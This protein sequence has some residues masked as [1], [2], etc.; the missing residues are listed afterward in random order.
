MLMKAF[1]KIGRHFAIVVIALFCILGIP[2]LQSDVFATWKGR[3]DVDAVSGASVIVDKPSGE[4]VVLINGQM[5]LSEEG[6]QTWVDFFE[7]KE[8]SFI[9]EDITCYV[10][11]QDP[12]GWKMALSFQSRLPENQMTVRREDVTLML[13]KAEYGKYDIMI[14]SREV[15]DAYRTTSLEQQ[16]NT[17][18]LKLGGG[19]E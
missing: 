19:G 9:F 3:G 6:L 13:S 14:L 10:A 15:A 18:V 7:G 5:H 17:I 12:T 11:K 8:V 2:F 4:Y 16:E 1:G